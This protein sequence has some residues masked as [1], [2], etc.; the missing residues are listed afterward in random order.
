[1]K[2]FLQVIT[3]VGWEWFG[4]DVKWDVFF[5]KIS[6][7]SSNSKTSQESFQKENYSL[8]LHHPLDPSNRVQLKRAKGLDWMIIFFASFSVASSRKKI[9]MSMKS[10][11]YSFLVTEHNY[12]SSLYNKSYIWTWGFAFAYFSSRFS[13]T[14][15]ERPSETPRGVVGLV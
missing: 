14:A 8:W 1:M 12:W 7:E 3:K 6:A 15:V 4:G 2:C 10:R 9:W 5:I 13:S 11:S